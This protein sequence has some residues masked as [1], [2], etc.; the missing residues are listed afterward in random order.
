MTEE[1]FDWQG[2]R[3]DQVDYSIS[4]VS[5]SITVFIIAILISLII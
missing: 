5:I 4:M 1:D 2:K 3:K